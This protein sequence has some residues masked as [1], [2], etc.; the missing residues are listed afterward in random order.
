MRTNL[1]GGMA[2][3]PTRPCRPRSRFVSVAP[4]L[5]LHFHFVA[6]PDGH[7]QEALSEYQVK[8]AYLFNFLKFVQRPSDVFADPLAP[9]V[10]GIVGDNPIGSALPEVVVGMTPFLSENDR[11]RFAIKVDA[12]S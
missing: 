11:V 12:T 5:F 1:D 10:I 9:P 8:D 4:G 6:A 2:R 7:A 3:F